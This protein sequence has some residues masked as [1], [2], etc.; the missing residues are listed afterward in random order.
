MDATQYLRVARRFW[1]LI[2]A[3]LILGLGIAWVT[4]PKHKPNQPRQP[5][6]TYHATAT[7][8]RTPDS[9]LNNTG[10]ASHGMGLLAL[11]AKTGEVPKRVAARL[12]YV[13]DPAVLVSGLQ[14]QGD[15]ELGTLTIQ[16]SDP[17]NGTRAADLANGDAEELMAYLTQQAQQDQQQALSQAAAQV[18]QLQQTVQN[19]NA[20]IGNQTNVPIL[21]AQRDAELSLYGAAYQRLQSLTSG[22]P[23]T[24]GLVFLQ[25]ATAIPVFQTGILGTSSSRTGRAVIGLIAGLVVGAA[26]ALG[27]ARFDTRIRDRDEAEMAFQLP[28]VAEIPPLPRRLRRSHEVSVRTR[29]L[30]EIAETYRTVRTALQFMPSRVPSGASSTFPEE[31][32]AGAASSSSTQRF[33][34]SALQRGDLGRAPA[35]VLVTSPGADEGKTTTVANLA[36][37]F[38]EAGK[39]V[40]VVGCD[41]RHSDLDRFVGGEAGPGLTELLERGPIVEIP[42]ELVRGTS[43]PGVRIMSTGGASEGSTGLLARHRGFVGAI[44]R[45]AD[46]VLIDTPPMLVSSEAPDLAPEVDTIVIV[47]RTGRTGA[48]TARRSTELLA[49]LGGPV[50]GVVLV[51]STER[52]TGRGYRY[53][54]TTAFDHSP[55]TSPTVGSNGRRPVR[56]PAPVRLKSSAGEGE[57]PL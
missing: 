38:A 13:G 39:T 46:V 50:L 53:Y 43:I 4:T 56:E 14:I 7:L 45:L 2:V 54:S 11:L 22:P 20:Q 21:Q 17:A 15:N 25:R 47:A 8:I 55:E 24:S 19:L 6:Q 29:P 51:G 37:C 9:I 34:R 18:Q 36:A 35:V 41:F 12:H 1:R 57:E 3:C 26:L 30:S 5:V 10:V 27:V 49:R 42:P 48:V 28:V 16:A 44:R 31:D 32:S 52:V 40:L 33:L 23:A